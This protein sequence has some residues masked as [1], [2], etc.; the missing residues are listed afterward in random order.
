MEREFYNEEIISWSRK[1]D[2]FTPLKV[3]SCQA[4][5]TNRLCGDRIF[6]EMNVG[7]SVIEEIAFKIQGCILCKAA[8]AHLAEI[9]PGRNRAWIEKTH[10]ELE[11][12]LKA[13][14]DDNLFPESHWF[15]KPV[16]GHRS[17]YSCLLLPYEAAL[18]ALRGCDRPEM[19]FRSY[20]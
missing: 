5:V 2:C 17:R 18:K 14:S 7:S 15:F 16:K 19:S 9:A 8:A 3:S 11:Y 4:L 12:A 6:I 13:A 1:V 10:S 20:D